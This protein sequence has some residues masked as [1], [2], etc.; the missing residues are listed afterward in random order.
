M[1]IWRIVKWS[2]AQTGPEKPVCRTQT[3][4][5]EFILKEVDAESISPCILRLFPKVLW[6]KK[7]WP[8]KNTLRSPPPSC[9]SHCSSCYSTSFAETSSSLKPGHIKP[10]PQSE[11]FELET[12]FGEANS[13]DTLCR[14]TLRLAPDDFLFQTLLAACRFPSSFPFK[15]AP[16]TWFETHL[17]VFICWQKA[18]PPFL[19]ELKNLPVSKKPH[20]VNPLSRRPQRTQVNVWDNFSD[21]QA[22][23][24]ETPPT[25]S[26]IHDQPIR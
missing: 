12:R 9:C 4:C 25:T 16:A 1:F 22:A 3:H 19:E 10:P 20:R 11:L 7:S 5:S 24:S 14:D 2:S 13:R 8:W 21:W 23:Y 26:S 17:N 6:R 15:L 18:L